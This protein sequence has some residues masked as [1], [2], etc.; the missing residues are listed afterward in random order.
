MKKLLLASAA[1]LALAASASAATITADQE[2]S[3]VFLSFDGVIQP[4]DDARF[5]AAWSE[6]QVKYGRT[7]EVIA[8]NSVGGSVPVS[9]ALHN[10]ISANHINT[11]VGEN[12]IC[13]SACFD[14]FV[15]GAKRFVASTAKIG[16]HSVI[17]NTALDAQG[18]G[19]EDGNAAQVTLMMARYYAKEGVPA[20]IIAKMVATPPDQITPLTLSDVAGWAT[21]MQPQAAPQPAP[22]AYAPPAPLP[23]PAP[24]P[25]GCDLEEVNAADYASAR[26]QPT[27]KGRELWRLAPHTTVRW[28]GQYVN[29]PAEGIQWHWISFQWPAEPWTHKAWVARG[30]LTNNGSENEQE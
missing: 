26:A 21:V 28:C 19:K 30:I 10:L 12:A 8:L 13:A 1:S 25:K 18:H 24:A 11:L 17:D 4:G 27:L 5:N 16:V 23:R 14:L 3:V 20:S 22:A 15:A 7:P 6:A 2:N 9:M 29:A